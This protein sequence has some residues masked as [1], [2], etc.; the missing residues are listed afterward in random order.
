MHRIAALGFALLFAAFPAL[1]QDAYPSKP[2]TLIVPYA[3]G[4]GSD[5]LGRVLA[6]GLHARLN[7]TVVVQ[8][9]AGAGSVVGSQQVAKAKPD[10]Y[11][12]LI[13]HMGLSTIPALYKKVAFDPLGSFEFVGLY[14]EAPM[15]IMARKAFAP[16]TFA[17]LVAYVKA[18]PDKFT[19][20]SAGMG[21]ATHLCAILFQQVV[22]VPLTIVQYKG[23]GPAVI[24][25]RSGQV[26]A[27]CDLPTTTS[28]LVR[29][30]DLRGYLLTAPQRLASLPDVPTSKELG[31]PS[32]DIAVWFAVYAPAGTPQPIVTTLNK[33]LREIVQDKAVAEKLATI[34]TYL[35]PLDQATPEAH[36]AKLTSQIARWTPILEKA[37]VSA[38]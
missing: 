24:D 31:V 1:A 28:A 32:L 37:G 34:E 36:R 38:E 11:T 13:N 5:L 22:G 2:I 8:N 12:L 30:G 21:S 9:L 25:V 10:G 29:S 14:A 19:M 20:A 3:P 16:Q 27:I 35:L 15:M 6:E 23:A 7:Q 18:H 17:E 33:A 26:D 4:G